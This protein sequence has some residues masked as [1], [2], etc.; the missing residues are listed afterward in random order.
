MRCT[1]SAHNDSSP[2]EVLWFTVFLSFS[3]MNA[4]ICETAKLRTVRDTAYKWQTIDRHNH[5]IHGSCVVHCYLRQGG[6]YAM[7]AVCLS[8]IHS[9]YLSLC[10]QDYC[11]SNQP[12]SLKL[13]VINGKKL[14]SLKRSM[15]RGQKSEFQDV[16]LQKFQFLVTWL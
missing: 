8:W 5:S 16:E 10:M 11:K 2:G 4:D 15:S 13:G 7:G 9:F 14:N 6:G 3:L 12:I 1:C